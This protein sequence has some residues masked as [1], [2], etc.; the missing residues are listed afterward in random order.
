[1]N[2]LKIIYF[3][4]LVMATVVPAKHALHMFQQNRYELKRYSAW[5]IENFARALKRGVIPLL[6]LIVTLVPSIITPRTGLVVCVIMAALLVG[7]EIGKEREAQYIKPLVYTGR[8]KRQIVVLAIILL[9]IYSTVFFYDNKYLNWGVLAL[10]Y[11]GPWLL[12]FVVGGITSPIEHAVQN[13]YLKDAKK[14]L[15]EHT[16]LIKIGITGSYGKTST[17]NVM[18]AV[19]SEKYNTLMTPASYNTPMGITRT[20]RDMLKPIHRV[21]VCEMGADKVGDISELMD[22]VHPSIGVITSIGPQHLATFGSQENITKE[23]MQMIEQLPKDGLGVLNYDNALIRQYNVQNPVSLVTYGIDYTDVDYRAEQI[24]YSEN[25]STFVVKHAEDSISFET[26]LLGKLNILNILAT[27]AVA[28]HLGIS[29]PLIQRAVKEMKQ[30]EHR[31]E[32]KK[33]NGLTFIDDAFNANPSGAEM[34]IDVLSKMDGKRFVVTPGM[35]DLGPQ[36]ATIN[37]TFGMQMVGKVDE[38]ILVGEDQVRPI[39][40]GL[41]EAGFDMDHVKVVSSVKEAFAIIW[42]FA[43]KEDKILLENDL[44]DAFSH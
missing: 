30:V 21:F 43:T 27:I 3:G 28:R 35:I 38:V 36:Q 18:Q 29:W 16:N 37:H 23:K 25:G 2:I 15:E 10:T 22:F 9:A 44:P 6:I 32:L 1:M 19:I 8:V 26:K 7:Y 13:W 34:A 5:L 39:Y 33:I 41:E 12:M 31:L 17:K 40:E 11:I 14:H 42:A 4:L 24:A 20:V